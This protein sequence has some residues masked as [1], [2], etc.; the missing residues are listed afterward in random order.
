MSMFRKAQRHKAKLRLALSGVSG[1]GKSYSALLIAGGIA[2][3][4]VM[5]DTERGSGDLYEG[6]IPYD[7]FS[8][9]PPFDPNKLIDI[10][11]GA[12]GEG[13]DLIIFDSLSHFWSDEGGV[14]SIVDKVASASRSKNSFAAWN[15][16]TQIQNMLINTI[17][18]CKMHVI[19]TLRSKASYEI[20]D[21]NGKKTPTKLG[22]APIQRD[23]LE[24]E[25][26]SMLELDKETHLANSGGTGKDRTD[27]FEG[28]PPFVPSKQTG[29]LLLEWLNKGASVPASTTLPPKET[30]KT[31]QNPPALVSLENILERINKSKTIVELKN[32]WKKYTASSYKWSEQEFDLLLQTKDKHKTV[33]NKSFSREMND[34]RKE[35]EGKI[36]ELGMQE[37]QWGDLCYYLTKDDE[38]RSPDKL[39][40]KQLL[41]FIQLLDKQ[42]A[43]K[44]SDD[45]PF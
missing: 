19:I 7:I 13:Y 4:I 30:E 20:V 41:Q 8:F 18:G 32:V 14:L 23:G 16:G 37:P 38:K 34:L 24:Y 2:K 1:S 44:N 40:K 5:V 31:K 28:K 17:L 11:Q 6:L 33:L 36:K 45:T 9:Q 26:T 29:E 12:E 10:I 27:V 43:N 39:D 15:K 21:H 42:L 22:L 35:V 25:F 3:K